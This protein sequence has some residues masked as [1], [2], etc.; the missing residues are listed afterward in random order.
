[1]RT[2]GVNRYLE[3]FKI[4]IIPKRNLVAQVMGSC[5]SLIDW[6]VIGRHSG[7]HPA[8]AFAIAF[9]DAVYGFATMQ[10]KNKQLAFMTGI[11][12]GMTSVFDKGCCDY[13]WWPPAQTQQDE[14]KKVASAGKAQIEGTC[15]DPN[16]ADW[17]P[18]PCPNV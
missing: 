7:I 18:V 14:S 17:A 3:R 9:K 2:V 16:L 15:R 8:L 1:M 4:S 6:A 5:R 13:N 11:Q 10:A 12:A